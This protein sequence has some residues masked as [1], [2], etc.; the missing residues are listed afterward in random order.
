[1]IKERF[2]QKNFFLSEACIEYRKFDAC[3]Y[4]DNA[5][6]YAHD[7]IGNFNNG[8]NTF[9]DWNLILDEQGI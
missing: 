7:M 1:M 6:K 3:N 2:P 9:L 8:M 4:L 5:Q